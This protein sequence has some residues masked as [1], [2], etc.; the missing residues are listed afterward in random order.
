M[1]HKHVFFLLTILFVLLAAACAP[2]ATPTSAPALAPPPTA[3]P[4]S[5]PA[6]ATSIPST[7]TPV[8]LTRLR[9]PYTAISVAMAPTWVAFEQGLFKKEGLDVTIEYIATSP[10][11]TAA[12]L[13]G[14][15]Q[16]AEAAEDVVITSGLQGSDLVILAS[17]GDHLLFSL[18]TKPQINSV[19]D[20]KGKTIAVTRRG[21]STDFAAHWLLTQNN[22]VPEK[23]NIA[24][25][26]TGGVPD[27]L[28]AMQTGQVDA[29][30][31][32]PPTTIRARQAG[33]KELVDISSLALTF[34]Q[35]PV[36]A[37]KSWVASNADTLRKFMRA[38]VGAIAVM[39]KDKAATKTIIGKYTQTT[40]DAT[41]EES[42]NSFNK[43]LPQ[44]PIPKLEAIKVGLD[45]AATDIP[46][47]KDADPNLFFDPRWVDEL[48]KNGFIAGLYK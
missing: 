10:L 20:L 17:G 16:I 31:L 39:K 43:I 28:T 37:R 27:I 36:I 40:D 6:T 45:Q 9:V 23:D 32:S 41:L 48:D 46:K 35:A 47:A 11:L 2:G 22:L 21:S 25:I 1:I 26:N 14:E 12:M 42:Y 13:N 38:Y 15:V 29:G 8:P 4:T 18:F 7:S 34:Y 33:F 5:A 30:V 24:F 3:P 44:V 19:Q